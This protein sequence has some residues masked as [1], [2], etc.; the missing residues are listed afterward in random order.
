QILENPPGHL[1]VVTRLAQQLLPPAIA[2]VYS[3][4]LIW[5]QGRRP[6]QWVRF[7]GNLTRFDYF[8]LATALGVT[9]LAAY[10]FFFV[11]LYFQ[12]HWY[13]PASTLFMSLVFVRLW[14][15]L[16]PSRWTEGTTSARLAVVATVAAAALSIG[17]FV[18]FRSPDNNT[19]YREFFYE[20]APLVRDHY[21]DEAPRLLSFEDGIVAFATGFPTMSG[22]GLTLDPEATEYKM[23]H[24]LFTIAMARGH[25]R[26]TGVTYLDGSRLRLGAR[27]FAPRRF[28]GQH[29]HHEDLSGYDF[30]VEYKSADGRFA[31]VRAEPS[32][33]PQR[34]R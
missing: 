2:L 7:R 21:G 33:R 10:N 5:P 15:R 27:G 8:L 14:M 19:R 26:V 20:V 34:E 6:S 28:A 25:D 30:V 1:H 16:T 13:F 9:A 32:Q 12:G 11:E 24:D 17:L 4:T 29:L 22:I 18:H 23:A 31:I 3:L